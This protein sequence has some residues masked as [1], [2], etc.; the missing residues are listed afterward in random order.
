MRERDF[1]EVEA[2]PVAD[3]AD[4]T[5]IER[6]EYV[7]REFILKPARAPFWESA[8]IWQ[9]HPRAVRSQGV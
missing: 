7:V 6:A 2:Q 3:T 8:R 9:K 4:S 5:F 1:S